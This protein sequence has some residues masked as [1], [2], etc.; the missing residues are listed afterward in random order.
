M[1]RNSN[2]SRRGRVAAAAAAALA[3]VVVTLLTALTALKSRINFALNFIHLS[4]DSIPLSLDFITF[5]T[6]LL[7]LLTLT[8]QLILVMI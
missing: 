1:S 4:A 5:R 8:A 6:Q 7:H 3:V 2:N